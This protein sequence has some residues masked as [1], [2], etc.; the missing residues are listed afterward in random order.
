MHWFD[1]ARFGMFIH[2]THIANRG[3]ELSWPLV[4]GLH[5][6]PHAEG[7]PVADY[8]SKALE[9]CPERGAASEWM[10]L[11]KRAGMRYAVLTTKHHD[12]FAL[13]PSKYGDFGIANTRYDGDLV[14]EYVDAA[15][16]HGL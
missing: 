2:W 5:V 13:W 14:A 12:G 7:V 10:A 11:A 8:Y 16:E 6:L 4:G 15:R 1:E 9:F 3:L